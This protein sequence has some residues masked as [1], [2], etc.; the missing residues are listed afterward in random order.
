M[1]CGGQAVAHAAC[2]P[3]PPPALHVGDRSKGTAGPLQFGTSEH[4]NTDDNS[5]NC[6]NGSADDTYT[7]DAH[8]DDGDDDDNNK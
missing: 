6:N 1:L 4:H 2:P 5:N 3:T 7:N 8:D